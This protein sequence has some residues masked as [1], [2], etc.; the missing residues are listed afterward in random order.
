MTY[1]IKDGYAIS[2]GP[3]KLTVSI[4]IKS[5]IESIKGGYILLNILNDSAQKSLD[6]IV[7]ELE[8]HFPVGPIGKATYREEIEIFL[9]ELVDDGFL[10]KK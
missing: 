4:G 5:E 1:K 9:D 3:K 6:D 2:I 7:S 10:E 8:K